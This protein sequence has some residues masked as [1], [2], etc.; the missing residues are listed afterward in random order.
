MKTNR[1]RS[2]TM[3]L[4]LLTVAAA[5]AAAD[6]VS[7]SD[8]KSVGA[9]Y[10]DFTLGKFNT[11]LG[12]LTAVEIKVDFS[13]LAGSF[14][15][16][17]MSA[18]PV[19]V[20]A[21]DV[22]FRVRESAS[23]AIGYTLTNA[24]LFDAATSPDWNTTAVSA[25]SSQVYTIIGG[26]SYTINAQNIDAGFFS[27]YQS[28][29]GVGSVIM[30]GRNTPT[31]AAAGGTYS[32]DPTSTVANTKMTVTYTYTAVPEPATTGLLAVAAGGAMLLAARRRSKRG[33]S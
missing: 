12:T 29:G 30:Q 15:V 8:T 24:T 17:S 9:A 16:T 25:N 28:A 3:Q 33:Q 1:L 26:Q 27:A 18:S 23:N 11:G 2:A 32:V 13:T 14:T 4:L 10:A 19:T 31:I 5:T 6:T 21:F 7:F 20:T 22:A